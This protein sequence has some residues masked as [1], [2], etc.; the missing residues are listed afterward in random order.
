LTVSIILVNLEARQAI[1]RYVY[2]SLRKLGQIPFHDRSPREL[3]VHVRPQSRG[4]FST[5]FCVAACAC[6]AGA[7]V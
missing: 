6:K 7:G 1:R 3:V 2:N 5:E 4:N